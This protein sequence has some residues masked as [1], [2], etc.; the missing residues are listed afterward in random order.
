MNVERGKGGAYCGR[1]DLG[2]NEEEV[3]SWT[4]NFLSV[5]DRGHTGQGQLGGCG[6]LGEEGRLKPLGELED[7]EAM[8]NQKFLGTGRFKVKFLLTQGILC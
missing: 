8:Y 1:K 3:W 4:R 2:E 5:A 6:M 7:R